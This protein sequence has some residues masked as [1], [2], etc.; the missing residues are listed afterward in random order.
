MSAEQPPDDE[1]LA[2]RHKLR[3]LLLV[4]A[5]VGFLFALVNLAQWFASG[6]GGFALLAAL[7]SSVGV[8]LLYV[9]HVARR[10]RCL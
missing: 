3:R 4:V 2:E 6:H 5:L 7:E 9:R 1:V 10:S 8:G